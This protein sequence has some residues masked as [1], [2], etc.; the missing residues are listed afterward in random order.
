M[1]DDLKIG[2]LGK[3]VVRRQWP[4]HDKFHLPRVRL[5]SVPD[6]ETDSP[7]DDVHQMLHLEM[8]ECLSLFLLKYGVHIWGEEGKLLSIHSHPLHGPLDKGPKFHNDDGET[9][10][11]LKGEVRR[12]RFEVDGGWLDERRFLNE[13]GGN[14]N[15]YHTILAH[16]LTFESKLPLL[17]TMST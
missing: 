13:N 10:P 5:E 1:V 8:R 6:L 4:L 11:L 3:G 9:H 15:R 17:S 7:H 2:E 14:M 12:A 16:V